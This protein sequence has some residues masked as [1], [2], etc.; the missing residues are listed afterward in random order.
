MDMFIA[1]SETTSTT[2]NWAMLFMLV[3]PKIQKKVNESIIIQ[4]VSTYVGVLPA[5]TIIH[6][7]SLIS[8]KPSRFKRS[9]TQILEKALCLN[10]QRES[11]L[12]IRKL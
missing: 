9:W 8:L 12:L 1:G 2:L 3:N 10:I 11:R 4:W 7:H 5:I 6:G